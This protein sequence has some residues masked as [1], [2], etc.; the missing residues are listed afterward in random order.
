MRLAV[1][2]T[3][4]KLNS[5]IITQ[6]ASLVHAAGKWGGNINVIVSN[7]QHFSNTYFKL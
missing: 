1:N 2:E 7:F 4:A 5:F 6:V 3:A